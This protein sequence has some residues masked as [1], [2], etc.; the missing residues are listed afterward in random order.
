M[1][2]GDGKREREQ[3]NDKRVYIM[4]QPATCNINGQEGEHHLHVCL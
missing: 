1:G 3:I 4:P 2:L